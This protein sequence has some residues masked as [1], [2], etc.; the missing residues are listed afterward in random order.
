MAYVEY[1]FDNE[2]QLRSQSQEVL[3][4]TA[5]KLGFNTARKSL[6]IKIRMK[7]GVSHRSWNSGK[8]VTDSEELFRWLV[9]GFRAGKQ[10]KRIR[11]R[12]VLDQYV[13]L[14][15]ED[16]AIMCAVA[17]RGSG[18]ITEKCY[19]AGEMILAD[20]K[21]KIYQGSFNLAPNRGKYAERKWGAGYGDVPLVA[22]KALINTLEVVVE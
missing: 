14:Y 2:R 22:T 5:L 13:Q 8:A 10:K 12:P 6:T 7:K 16:I 9:S 15:S 20:L 3:N 4:K 17:F 19:R 21:H 11:G 1:T 18:N